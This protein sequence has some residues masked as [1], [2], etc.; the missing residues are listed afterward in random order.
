MNIFEFLSIF[1]DFY[2][3]NF[4]FLFLIYFFAFLKEKEREKNKWMIFLL[5][6]TFYLAAFFATSLKIVFKVERP[7]AGLPSCPTSYAFPSVHAAIVFSL[8]TSVLLVKRKKRYLSLLIFPFLVSYSRIALNYHSLFDILGGAVLGTFIAYLNFTFYKKFLQPIKF[9]NYE[10][11]KLIHIS[12]FSLIFFLRFIPLNLIK[13]LIGCALVLFSLSEILRLKNRRFPFFYDLTI[14]CLQKE[15]RKS[16]AFSPLLYGISILI[17]LNLN[18]Y[19]FYAGFV[20]LVIG[21]AFAGLIG[22]NFGKK[23]LFNQKTLEG[24]LSFFLSSFCFYLFY[25]PLNYSLILALIATFIEHFC[26]RGENLILPLSTSFLTF[27]LLN[28]F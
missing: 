1:G 25:F 15:E 27:L 16:F 4:F 19:L 3:W 21:D 11:R 18:F 7:C 14:H 2:F 24:S 9:G 23:K 8:M 12:T 13:V 17:L 6:P 26:K 10:M 5:I 22:K 28:F 20:A